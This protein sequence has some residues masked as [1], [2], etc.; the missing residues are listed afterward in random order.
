MLPLSFKGCEL[1]SKGIRLNEGKEMKQR[2]FFYQSLLNRPC[3]IIR[4]IILH[5]LTFHAS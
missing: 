3:L 1:G 5:Q 4:F 2:Y